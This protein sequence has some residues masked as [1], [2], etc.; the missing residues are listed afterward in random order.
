MTGSKVPSSRLIRFALPFFFVAVDVLLLVFF[1]LGGG[2]WLFLVLFLVVL[3]VLVLPEY[4]SK[5]VSEADR[6]RLDFLLVPAALLLFVQTHFVSVEAFAQGFL[7]ITQAPSAPLGKD[8][9]LISTKSVLELKMLASSALWAFFGIP[10]G[11]FQIY[12]VLKRGKV[13]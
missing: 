10:A 1:W 9:T 12:S 2:I 6:T 4:V 11:G 7:S 8:N 5:D 13:L 3:S